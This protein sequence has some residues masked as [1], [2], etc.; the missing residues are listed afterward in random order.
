MEYLVLS[1]SNLDG[2]ENLVN[3]WIGKGWR[4]QGGV[5]GVRV[6]EH[7]GRFYQAMIRP[8][9]PDDAVRPEPP[10]MNFRPSPPPPPPPKEQPSVTEIRDEW[11]TTDRPRLWRQV[12]N[13]FE[14][15]GSTLIRLLSPVS[16]ALWR[17]VTLEWWRGKD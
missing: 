3:R 10:I 11:L 14:W 1:A 17:T 2:L 4:P 5:C 13:G 9:D 6:S 16:H 15:L 12:D 7:S 8:P